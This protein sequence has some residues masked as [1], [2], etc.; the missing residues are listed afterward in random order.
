MG[1]LYTV[2]GGLR[3][4]QGGRRH[5]VLQYSSKLKS[6]QA[7]STQQ[8]KRTRTG[9]VAAEFSGAVLPSSK[10][11]PRALLNSTLALDEYPV[12]VLDVF[13]A[14]QYEVRGPAFDNDGETAVLVAGQ[15]SFLEL[16]A[17]ASQNATQQDLWNKAEYAYATFE[18]GET[19]FGVLSEYI[20]PSRNTQRIVFTPPSAGNFTFT[21]DMMVRDG[22]YPV[23]HRRYMTVEVLPATET[24]ASNA[25]PPLGAVA[26]CE[27]LPDRG[28]WARCTAA[29]MT[30]SHECLRMGHTF[31]PLTA[32]GVSCYYENWG[33]ED[34][35]R[36][37]MAMPTF[38][39][40]EQQ[41]QQRHGRQQQQQQ[42]LD[43]DI[44]EGE[45]HWIVFAGTSR[46]RGVFL[47]AVDHLL[48]GQPGEFA[49]ISKCW[50][51]MDVTMGS[52]LRLTYQDYRALTLAPWP[53]RGPDEPR[54]FQCHDAK[55]ATLDGMEFYHNATQ[56]ITHIFHPQ[57]KDTA[58]RQPTSLMF[59]KIRDAKE[60]LYRDMLFKHLPHDWAGTTIAFFFRSMLS[61]TSTLDQPHLT[62]ET[63]AAWTSAIGWPTAEVVD[64]NDIIKPWMRSAEYGT[65]RAS[66]HWHA[67]T[68]ASAAGSSMP[69]A[70]RGLV[71]DL[72]AQMVFNRVLGPKPPSPDSVAQTRAGEADVASDDGAEMRI[73]EKR[74]PFRVCTDCPTTFMPFHIKPRSDMTNCYDHVPLDDYKQEYALNVPD[75]PAWCMSQPPASLT[76][77]QSK[78]VEVRECVEK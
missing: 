77:T 14:A 43:E 36:Y 21:V 18:N 24:A 78:P 15:P 38:S 50:G 37:V 8:S 32:S 67:S 3:L 64:T 59:E 27:G 20:E 51:R 23:I 10:P 48:G 74:P 76:Q 13:D 39:N 71:T 61:S 53:L 1:L 17:V 6:K 5:D 66:H 46:L 26:R 65:G 31:R 63:K 57:S 40:K 70:V 29:G 12:H 60:E 34:L 28:Q 75:C 22:F 11:P 30:H 44:H 42:Q 45:K 54:T 72:L 7:S 58:F 41:Q 16:K 19:A 35:W 56:F 2:D 33:T 47:A 55:Q 69:F 9:K 68:D 73:D 25:P 49:Q 4:P 62:P 52:R